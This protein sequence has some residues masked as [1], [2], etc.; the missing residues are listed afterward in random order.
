MLARVLLAATIVL[1]AGP[2]SA[3]QWPFSTPARHHH[4]RHR[5]E[6]STSPVDHSDGS[7]TTPFA[8]PKTDCRELLEAEREKGGPDSQPWKD[9]VCA[10]TEGQRSNIAKCIGSVTKCDKAAIP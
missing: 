8:E 3:F 2:S 10:L 5:I 6:R 9:Q 4:H 7:T 1:I